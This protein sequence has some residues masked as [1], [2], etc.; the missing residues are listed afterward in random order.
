LDIS[1]DA[2]NPLYEFSARFYAPALGTFTQLDTYPGDAASVLSLNRYLY[3]GANPWTLIDP[4]GHKWEQGPGGDGGSGCTWPCTSSPAPQKSTDPVWGANRRS[5][6]VGTS[7]NADVWV[8]H[9]TTGE[10]HS[11]GNACVAPTWVYAAAGATDAAL[12][13]F[14]AGAAFAGFC[15]LTGGAACAVAGL[16]LAVASAP[17]TVD[18]IAF[19]TNPSTSPEDRMYAWG[20]LGGS[21]AFGLGGYKAGAGMRGAFAP[22]PPAVANRSTAGSLEI[23]GRG[24]SESEMGSAQILAGRGYSVVLRQASGTQRMSDVLLDGIAYDIYTPTTPNVAAVVSAVASKGNQ[25]AGGGVVIDVSRTSLTATDLIGILSRVRNV[26]M[27]VSDII[28]VN[29]QR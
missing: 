21:V 14:A 24:F 9:L 2:A 25:V 3:A 8:H 18:T 10:L 16:S 20:G 15:A 23:R 13:A 26:T 19:A 12:P 1:P 28:I 27:N 4:S 5:A 17:A 11:C 7:H 6:G 29:S 22:R